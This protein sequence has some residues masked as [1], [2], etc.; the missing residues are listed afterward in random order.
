MLHV[1]T[2]IATYGEHYNKHMSYALPPAGRRHWGS[3]D[4]TDVR[5]GKAIYSDYT[6]RFCQTF[7]AEVCFVLN[8][9]VVMKALIVI[10]TIV[11]V[12]PK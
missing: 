12:L 5:E 10:K 4:V 2:C 9:Y 6:E 1:Q 7:P 11:D 3:W 8:Y